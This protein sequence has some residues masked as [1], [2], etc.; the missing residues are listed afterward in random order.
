[1]D[2]H[3]KSVETALK[4]WKEHIVCGGDVY[5]ICGVYGVP[6]NFLP[7]KGRYI[8]KIYFFTYYDE[9]FFGFV[10]ENAKLINVKKSDWAYPSIVKKK[11]NAK[12]RSN[13]ENK[14]YEFNS[15]IFLIHILY[16]N[17]FEN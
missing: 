10:W 2:R 5:S 6:L 13:L 16:Y 12:K 9:T 1:M 17:Y 8:G 15:T 4:H 7:I 3:I 11:E 14:E